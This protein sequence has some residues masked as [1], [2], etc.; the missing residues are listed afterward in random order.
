[1]NVRSLNENVSI[2]AVSALVFF[3]CTVTVQF[4]VW[5]SLTICFDATTVSITNGVDRRTSTLAVVV[6]PLSVTS[7]ES[8]SSTPVTIW[9]MATVP[10]SDFVL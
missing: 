3:T 10:V 9:L 1:M 6:A 8:F 5:L 7:R 2:S 4:T